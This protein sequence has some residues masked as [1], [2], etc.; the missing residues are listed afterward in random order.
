MGQKI[1]MAIEA[2]RGMSFLHSN[3]RIHRDLKS[4]NLLVR[5]T[6]KF[7]FFSLQVLTEHFQVDETLAVKVA[8]FGES[9]AAETNMT[10]ATGTYNW[11][12]PEVLTSRNYTAKADVFSFGIILWELLMN[13]LP[14]RS[15]DDVK[16]CL[17]NELMTFWHVVK[18]VKIQVRQN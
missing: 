2:A 3:N 18:N 4:L 9:R 7:W 5:E 14:D 1:Q 6:W 8:D 12:A 11:M 13:R 16:V 17:K 10:I 15:L